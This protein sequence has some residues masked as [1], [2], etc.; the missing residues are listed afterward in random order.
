M[1]DFIKGFFGWVIGIFVALLGVICLAAG[2]T[3]P[4]WYGMIGVIVAVIL[5][6]VLG[7]IILAKL[8]GD[9]HP[10]LAHI[11]LLLFLIVAA[12]VFW[13]ADP[14]YC[15]IS[16]VFVFDSILI[17]CPQWV[18]DIKTPEY[19]I[20][21][22]KHAVSFSEDAFGDVS[23]DDKVV[24]TRTEDAGGVGIGALIHFVIWEGPLIVACFGRITGNEPAWLPYLSFVTFGIAAIEILVFF[25]VH[26]KH[27]SRVHSKSKS[28]KTVK[29]ITVLEWVLR[30]VIVSVCFY[31]VPV[32]DDNKLLI[33]AA[34]LCIAPPVDIVRLI[35]TIYLMVS[36]GKKAHLSVIFKIC[37]F[38]FVSF[39]GGI[40]LF[41]DKDA[42]P[43][44]SQPT[45]PAQPERPADSHPASSSS[46]ESRN[47]PVSSHSGDS[48]I[49]GTDAA[50]DLDSLSSADLDDLL[51]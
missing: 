46:F 14:K 11:L 49:E 9:E 23:V 24:E 30:A 41:F 22:E 18:M 20:I 13:F 28:R 27:S 50:S 8:W 7:I 38:L 37:Y 2:L 1:I 12:C 10:V 34:L 15:W 42:E 31:T 39:I 45:S 47:A 32:S 43:Q 36:M 51:N 17:I 29:I 33:Y 3:T 16:C 40:L 44:T 21:H 35:I 5:F 26:L 48:S 4:E 19:K 25:I 6:A